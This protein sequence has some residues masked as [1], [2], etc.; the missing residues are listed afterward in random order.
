MGRLDGKVALVSG[1]ARGLGAAEARLFAQ[2]GAK[3]I[4]GDVLEVEGRRTAAEIG[5]AGG[6][7][8]FLKLDVTKEEDWKRAVDLAVS[9]FGKLTTLVNNAGILRRGNVEETS[10]EQWD[11]VMDINV[12]GVFLGTKYAIPAMRKA[13]GGSI[14]NT[15]SVAGL[16]GGGATAYTTSKGAV[17][18]LTKATAVQ[19]GKDGIRC[20]S[21]HP[22]VIDTDMLADALNDPE[23]RAALVSGIALG[24][25]AMPEEVATCVLFLASD[26]SSYV[27]GSELVVDGGMTAGTPAR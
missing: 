23:R 21:I 20:N 22:G 17:R 9:R 16:R 11:L 7:A 26:E 15:S 4:L 6:Q 14:I 1:A 19:Y 18:L 25:V 24:R 3:V 2:E 8:V 12:K 27:T 5:E 10:V 13:G